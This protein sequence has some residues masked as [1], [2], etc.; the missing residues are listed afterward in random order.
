VPELMCLD[1][2]RYFD[3]D[4]LADLAAPAKV[5]VSAGNSEPET[6]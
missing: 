5:Q 2:F 4:S 1:L 3:F 6:H